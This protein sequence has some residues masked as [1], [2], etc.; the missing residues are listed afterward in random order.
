MN[1]AKPTIV[2]H[3]MFSGERVTCW[4]DSPSESLRRFRLIT[5]STPNCMLMMV[6]R[7]T[8]QACAY[9]HRNSGL[10]YKT[11]SCQ[12][13]HCFPG[14]FATQKLRYTTNRVTPLCL[15]T[16]HYSRNST[17]R[18]TPLYL[19][20][21]QYSTNR[22]TPL[23]RRAEQYSTNR[24]TPLYRRAEQY[25]TN[26]I[27]PLY[28][29]AEQYSTNRVTPLYLRAEQYLDRTA[30]IDCH[31]MH[32][33]DR[34]LNLANNLADR[35]S[36]A[37][38]VKNDDVKGGRIAILCNNDVSYVVAEWATWIVQGIAVPL[39]HKHP[40]SE[41]KYFL[42]NSQSSLIIATEDHE[43]EIKPISDEIGIRS[44]ILQKCDYLSAVDVGSGEFDVGEERRMRRTNR[45]NQRLEVN[46]YK[47]QPALMVYTSGTTGRPKVNWKMLV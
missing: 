2:M 45:L 44:L 7:I 12:R 4:N 10:F 40:P 17:N 22:V 1:A 31:A 16:E 39:Y 21:E 42:R 46:K 30:L 33:Y 18:V 8:R 3:T 5:I 35:I 32:S 37:L 6:A 25:S 26:R 36:D 20:A 9:Q 27:T 28:L 15:R 41:Q 34:I 19:R 29:R 38:E 47:H 24:V 43:E 13:T 14:A 23:Y 11:L